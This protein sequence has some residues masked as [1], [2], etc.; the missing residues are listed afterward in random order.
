M[1]FTADLIA[2]PAQPSQTATDRPKKEREAAAAAAAAA[3]AFI[4]SIA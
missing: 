1:I 3:G 4:Q 2:A